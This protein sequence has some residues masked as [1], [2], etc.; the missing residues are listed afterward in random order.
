M[1]DF[2]MRR[3]PEF[4]ALRALAVLAVLL[5]HLNPREG[6]TVF[7]M[8]GVHLFLVLSG[9]LITSIVLNHVG[10]PHFFRAFYA[11][12]ILR[13]WPIYYLTLGSLLVIQHRL[14]NPPSWQGLP[15]YLTFTQN[16]WHWPLINMLVAIPPR[17]LRAFDHSWTL[18]VE[19]QFYL[20]WP[21]AVALIGPRR[22]VPMTLVIVGFGVWF[23]TLGFDTWI[24][25]NVCG[26][27]ALGALI[28]A[29][30]K[31]KPRVERNRWKLSLC[32]VISGSIGFAY[33]YWHFTVWPVGW[34]SERMAWRDSLQNFAFYTIHFGIVGFV[35]TNAGAWFLAPLRMRELT[36]FG[37]ISYGMYMY[38]IPVYWLVGGY[39]VQVG[40]PWTMWV[41]KISLSFLVATISYRYIELPILSLKRWF[42]YGPSPDAVTAQPSVVPKPHV[43]HAG[44]S[45]VRA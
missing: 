42:P 31:D 35:A 21:L 39:R 13:I 2:T 11:R 38:H 12:R 9:Y 10:T 32:F 15:Y 24:L 4:D 44:H 45:S 22:V 28:A 20:L 7:G 17:T 33:L 26:A 5:F 19:E 6:L 37:E 1:G 14:P 18:A 40:E 30:L 43:I 34:S 36:Y 29:I 25:F 16:T 27:F 8:T 23:K 3:V 41:T